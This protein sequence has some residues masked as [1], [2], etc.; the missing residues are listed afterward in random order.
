ML[1][2][3]RKSSDCGWPSV[4]CDSCHCCIPLVAETWLLGRQCATPGAFTRDNGNTA[5]SEERTQMV[6]TWPRAWL[7][8]KKRITSVGIS[9][10]YK[11]F[12]TPPHSRLEYTV[13]TKYSAYPTGGSIHGHDPE[14]IAF[15]HG[16]CTERYKSSAARAFSS[17]CSQ[18]TIPPRRLDCADE[19]DVH[20]L[21]LC[22]DPSNGG[23]GRVTEASHSRIQGLGGMGR[24]KRHREC[25]SPGG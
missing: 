22:C 1:R 15:S 10:P 23:R 14:S 11:I 20:I 5:S 7:A 21:G 12:H 24:K 3:T 25:Q 17:C 4:H 6:R 13:Q 2:T 18:F 8:E 16:C 19:P 9:N